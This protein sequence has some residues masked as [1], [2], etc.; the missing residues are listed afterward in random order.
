[1]PDR[2]EIWLAPCEMPAYREGIYFI[3]LSAQA[4][5]FTMTEGHYYDHSFP[6]RY[7]APKE[8][9]HSLL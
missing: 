9:K 3:S 6:L 8:T 5:N 1:M 2:R 4:E 7:K